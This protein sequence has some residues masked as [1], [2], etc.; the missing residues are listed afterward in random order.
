[1][2]F[3]RERESEQ[4]LIFM[5]PCFRRDDK[6]CRVGLPW[7]C[8]TVLPHRFLSIGITYQKEEQNATDILPGLSHSYVTTIPKASGFK[9]A[10]RHPF[11][12]RFDLLH[13]L[14]YPLNHYKAGKILPS[15]IIKAKG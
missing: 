12:I 2:S 13:I 4:P 10:A 1:M 11:P 14:S 5:D 9:A 8:L 3:P 6:I 15:R 7:G